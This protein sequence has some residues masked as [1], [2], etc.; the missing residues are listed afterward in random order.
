MQTENI[1]NNLFSR[2]IVRMLKHWSPSFVVSLVAN[3]LLLYVFAW[4]LA[5]DEH[6]APNKS[7]IKVY[8]A[9]KAEP[10]PVEKPVKPKPLKPKKKIVKK[11]QKPKELLKPKP[12]VK[13]PQKTIL[14]PIQKVE[15]IIEPTPVVEQVEKLQVVETEKNTPDEVP[16]ITQPPVPEKPQAEKIQKFVPFF[17]MT[18]RPKYIVDSDLLNSYYPDEEKEFGR[19]ATVEVVVVVDGNGEIIKIDIAKSAGEKFDFAAKQAFFDKVVLVQPGYIEDEA[20]TSRVVI[21][22]TF[23]IE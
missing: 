3:V 9:K 14:K 6:K 16:E 2:L 18:R 19:E 12:P 13:K 4:L 21:P 8:L 7:A 22:I 23:E 15:K 1:N 20:V 17:R 10:V 5:V 11:I